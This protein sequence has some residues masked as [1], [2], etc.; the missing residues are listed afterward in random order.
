MAI[1]QVS[2]PLFRL[3]PFSLSP[4]AP[5]SSKFSHYHRLHLE[6]NLLY[7]PCKKLL[8][9]PLAPRFKGPNAPFCIKSQI[10]FSL[11]VQY[12]QSCVFKTTEKPRFQ[13][14]PLTCFLKNAVMRECN[15]IF[16][17]STKSKIP[18]KQ[19][20]KKFIANQLSLDML[21]MHSKALIHS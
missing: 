15:I 13:T 14:G 16:L 19:T 12:N 3:F 2:L 7:S 20:H 17:I 1:G 5:N 9:A 21:S 6:C 18:I 11:P 10:A 8:R 4:N